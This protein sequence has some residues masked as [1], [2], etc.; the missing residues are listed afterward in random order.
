MKKSS[1]KPLYQE[2]YDHLL[3]DIKSGKYSGENRLPSEK[4]LAA[5]YNVSRITSKKALALLADNGIIKRMP[6]KG[7][8]I[9]DQDESEI[10]VTE[11]DMK[12]NRDNKKVIIGLVITDFSEAYGTGLLY[13]IEQE[14]ARNNMYLCFRRS[15]ES[16]KLEED[17]LNGLLELGVKGLIIMPVH[18]KHY[19]QKILRLVLDGFPIVILDRNLKGID[20]SFVGTDN[21]DASKKAT[22]YLL[23]SG[24]QYI[25]F[26]SPPTKDTSTLEDRIEGF[27][28]SHV[29]HGVAIDTSIWLTDLIITVPGNYNSENLRSDINKI[30]TLIVNNPNVTC[31]F[32]AEYNIA[33]IAAQAVKELGKRVP[34]DISILCFDS[35]GNFIGDH[36]FTHI[37]QNEVELGVTAVKLLKEQMEHRMNKKVVY[38]DTDLILGASTKNSEK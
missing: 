11:A 4:E 21:F 33:I 37:R 35:P 24:H 22:D 1:N 19:N 15:Y 16:Q 20:T 18:G 2:I 14:A 28:K 6:G 32:A 38:I 17:E 7:S 9:C 3:E 10:D 8:F 31:L 29:E 36:F 30:K 12:T 23:E 34:E 25:S 5:E 27:I 13:G 26:I